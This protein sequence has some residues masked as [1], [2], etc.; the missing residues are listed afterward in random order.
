[1]VAVTGTPVSMMAKRCFWITTF[2]QSP[3][4]FTPGIPRDLLDIWPVLPLII[5]IIW[6]GECLPESLD[7]IIA[8]LDS[9]HGDRVCQIG[10]ISVDTH[11]LENISA[12]KSYFSS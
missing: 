11:Y 3:T 12:P 10:L 4:F 5:R 7:D 1:M 2:P 6:D 9:E 8:L